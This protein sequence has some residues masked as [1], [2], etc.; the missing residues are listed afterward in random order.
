L[1][2]TA[3]LIIFP[4]STASSKRKKA[5]RQ[6]SSGIAF[7]VPGFSSKNGQLSTESCPGRV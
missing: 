3:G 1:F 6:G 2:I 7:Q 5:A 4:I